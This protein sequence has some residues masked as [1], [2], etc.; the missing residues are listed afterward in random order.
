MIRVKLE[1]NSELQ[2]IINRIPKTFDKRLFPS[3]EKAVQDVA[4]A[5]KDHWFNY[6]I[7]KKEINNVPPMKNPSRGYADGLKIEQS[8]DFEREI[9][10]YSKNAEFIEH[11]TSEIDMKQSHTKGPRSRVSKKGVPY[12]I[13]PFRW[14]TPKTVGFQN[15]MPAE[16]YNIVEKYKKM[17]TLVDADK[18]DYKTPN[19]KGEMVGRAKYNQDYDQLKMMNTNWNGMVRSTDSTG[20]DRSGG[21]FTFRV[22][23]AK[24]PPGSWIKPATPARNVAQALEN[25]Y[26][27]IAEEVIED[28]FRGDVERIIK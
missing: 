1:I 10:N 24:S 17:E 14:G 2:E 22:I 20:I 6:G 19:A 13:V 23:S 15:V 12:L 18:S 5:I 8:G 4:Y 28:A 21:Y 9:V 7:G 25:Y 11:G 3:T 27:H 16:I 26:Q